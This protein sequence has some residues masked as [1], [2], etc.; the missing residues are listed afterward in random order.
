MRFDLEKLELMGTFV[1]GIIGVT[2]IVIAILYNVKR[3]LPEKE[4]NSTELNQKGYLVQQGLKCLI[5][6]A[7]ILLISM[8]FYAIFL[9]NESIESD[10]NLNEIYDIAVWR[11]L[12][13]ISW[14]VGPLAII[15]DSM[16]DFLFYVSPKSLV[17]HSIQEECDHRLK[18]VLQYAT[19][20]ENK[21][22]IVL[23]HSWGSVIAN[24]VLGEN[25]YDCKLITLGSPLAS[26]CKRFLGSEI[27]IP[28]GNVKWINGYRYGDYIA[29]PIENDFVENKIISNGGHTNYWSQ[30]EIKELI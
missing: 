17:T 6:I 5:F 7:P 1:Y 22:I 10:K 25:E 12:P 29:G 13:Y 15:V 19:N 3:D 30:E 9:M 20:Q 24:N 27:L 16:G 14:I 23:S 21:E 18:T 26:L 28:K 2:P 4:K 8:I 11:V